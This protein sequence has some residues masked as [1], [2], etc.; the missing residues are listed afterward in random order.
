MVVVLVFLIGGILDERA[1]LGQI[2]RRKW[3]KEESIRIEKEKRIQEIQFEIV[4]ASSKRYQGLLDLSARYRF[5]RD[6]ELQYSFSKAVNSKT[7][8]DH[9]DCESYICEGIDRHFDQCERFLQRVYANLTLYQCYCSELSVLPSEMT[10]SEVESQGIPYDVYRRIEKNLCFPLYEKEVLAPTFLIHVSYNSPQGRK[11][12]RRDYVIVFE[13]FSALFERVR[14]RRE[15]RNTAVYQ[16][17]IMTN[18]L[19]YDILKRDGFRCVLCGRSQDHGITLHVDHIIPVSKGGKT[20][21][22]NLRTLC[23][24]CNM[25]KRDKYDEQGVN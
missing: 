2:R 24:E 4:K 19:R 20:E 15:A 5:D 25:G 6:I 17:K 18:S 22:S 13:H 3:L 23:S 14:Q 16:R 7:Q 1:K 10:Y 9:F 8:F 11:T 12:Y 21:Y